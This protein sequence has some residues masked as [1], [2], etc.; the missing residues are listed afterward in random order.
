[1]LT[2]VPLVAWIMMLSLTPGANGG[3]GPKIEEVD[4]VSYL[5]CYVVCFCRLV[6]LFLCILNLLYVLSALTFI[7]LSTLTLFHLSKQW[8]I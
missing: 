4:Q 5:S 1:M 6:K 7:L 8:E 3:A 2:W